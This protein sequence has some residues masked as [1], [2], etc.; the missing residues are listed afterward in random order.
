MAGHLVDASG[1]DAG[2]R[3][4]DV[5]CGTGNVAITAARRGG[6]VAGLDVTPAMIDR[7]RRNAGI[8]GVDGIEWHEGTAT[9][10]PFAAD[11]FDVTLSALGHMYGDPPEAAAGELRR[12]T[13]PG[14]RIGFTSWTP[15][16]LF[17]IVAGLVS[18]YLAPRDLPDLSE[19]PFMWGDPDVV[20]ERLSDHVKSLEFDTGTVRYPALSPAHF[21][22]DL[23]EHSGLFITFVE[24]VDDRSD[25]R[26]E[27]IRTI[28]R[29]FDA[30]ANV[31]ELEYLLATATGVRPG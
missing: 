20:E 31:V 29:H 27:T 14:G 8:A 5:G 10:L 15:T 21:W 23:T 11:S 19:P 3:I 16:G 22:R 17:P 25:L 2:D 24:K 9:A 6:A 1:V 30:G 12:V 18:T 4:L 28:E 7:A 26:Q 13:R